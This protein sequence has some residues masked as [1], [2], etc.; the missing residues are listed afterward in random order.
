MIY[1]EYIRIKKKYAE[2]Q[3]TYEEA[4]ERAENVAKSKETMQEWEWL[5]DKKREQLIA[6]CDVEDRIYYLRFIRRKK[7][8]E[9]IKEISYSEAQIYRIISK[10]KRAGK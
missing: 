7:I 5:L 8:R 1:E 10:I 3:K 2:A 4:L 9:I 6:S